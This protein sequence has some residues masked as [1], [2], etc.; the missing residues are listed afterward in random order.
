M[1][2]L[3]HRPSP[4]KNSLFSSAWSGHLRASVLGWHAWFESTAQDRSE[5][6][7]LPLVDDEDDCVIGL[8]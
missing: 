7:M 2:K 4:D 3:L 5:P 8:S 6:L 1:G